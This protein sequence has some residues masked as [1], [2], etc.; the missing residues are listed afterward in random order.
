MHYLL[1]ILGNR[2]LAE[3][4]FQDCWRRVIEKIDRFR[5]GEPF[6]PWLFRIG[7]N[8]AYDL[9]RERRRWRQPARETASG[10]PAPEPAVRERFEERLQARDLVRRLLAELAPVYREV[11]WLR[12][13]R[14]QSYA[15]IAHAC[16]LP[17]GTVKTRL[18]R[19]LQM[20]GSR[21]EALACAFHRR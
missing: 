2:E 9:L 18:R 19:A 16:H 12:Y 17:L 14:E 10:G 21:Y 15:E 6:G 7:R 1:A 8:R 20:V 4:A 13:F 3:D 11:L 5:S